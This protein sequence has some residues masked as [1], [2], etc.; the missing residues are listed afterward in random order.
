MLCL[1]SFRT[2][3]YP[4]DRGG[5]LLD[6]GTFL[7]LERKGGVESYLGR[8]FFFFFYIIYD[9]I[10]YF[11]NYNNFYYSKNEVFMSYYTLHNGTST[12]YGRMR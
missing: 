6:V 4:V 7:E 12:I 5:L 9:C 8:G 11:V 1:I 2:R 10:V 3:I